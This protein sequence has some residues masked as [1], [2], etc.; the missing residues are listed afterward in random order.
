M[1]R[2]YRNY[3]REEPIEDEY[4]EN[5]VVPTDGKIIRWLKSKTIPGFEGHNL[6]DVGKYFL[7]SLFKEDLNLRASSLSFNYFL[8]LFPTL[9]FILTLIAALPIRGVKSRLIS[10][11][12][13]LLPQS[14][15]KEISSTIYELLNH[16]NSGL[17]SLGFIMALY[18]SSNAF[19]SLINSFNRRLPEKVKRNWL[20]NR[21]QAV[22]LTCLV[23]VMVVLALIFL[24]WMFQLA[25][26]MIKHEW[27]GLSLWLFI[28]NTIEYTLI[29]ALIFTAIS[30]FYRFGP[31]HKR[32]WRFISPG[33][34]F[35]GVL[36]IIS[37]YLFGLYVNNFDAYNKI[38]GSIGAI[39]ALMVLIYINCLVIIVGFELNTSIDKA[40]ITKKRMAASEDITL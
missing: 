13:L 3:Q 2:F 27:F 9:I 25:A 35:A 32:K 11:L 17:L 18:F 31:A 15:W 24:T 22:G 26:Y 1:S 14:T 39:I 10:E 40:S 8:S 28:I 30:S 5:P 36:S 12:R 37:T 34:I 6:Y 21:I 33:S 29:V 20:Q 23:G 38:Y 4:H 16:Q 19:H 7:N